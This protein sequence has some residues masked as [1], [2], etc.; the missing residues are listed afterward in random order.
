MQEALRFQDQ[1][2]AIV[3]SDPELR[4]EFERQSPR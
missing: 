4:R 1:A 3:G 2:M